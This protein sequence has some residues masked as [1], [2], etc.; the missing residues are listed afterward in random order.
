M[1]VLVQVQLVAVACGAKGCGVVYGMT[2]TYYDARMA[3]H[4][5]FYC[6]NG[7]YRRFTGETED[8]KRARLAEAR[9]QSLAEMVTHYGRRASAAERSNAALRGWAT[10]RARQQARAFDDGET[11]LSDPT[12]RN[13]S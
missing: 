7:H 1:D 6:P 13:K 4:L 5:A 3:D 8:A 10:R 2:R 9:A 11:E 12:D